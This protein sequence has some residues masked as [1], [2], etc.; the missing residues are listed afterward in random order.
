MPAELDC[1]DPHC[2]IAEH[3]QARDSFLLDVIIAMIETSHETVPMGGGKRKKWDPDKNCFIESAMPGWREQVEP[4]RQDS[5]FWN[6]IWV[7]LGCAN[8]GNLFELKKHV[9]NK[10]HYAIRKCKAAAD[11]TRL[12]KL[13][14]ASQSGDAHLL[15]EMKSIKGGK[16]QHSTVTEHL[17]G[18]DGREAISE[19]FKNVYEALYNSAGSSD[20]MNEIKEK[21]KDL[22]GLG[23]IAQVNRVTGKVVKEACARMKPGKADVTGSFTSDVLLHGPDALFDYLAGVFR[24]FLVHGDVTL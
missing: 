14:E 4:L 8:S 1:T 24:S 6:S 13:L 16:K 15:R 20:E 12:Q 23:S 19:K 10:Y 22:I 7:S 18:V 3:R 9:R 17:D 2:D 11:A 5:M 21:L